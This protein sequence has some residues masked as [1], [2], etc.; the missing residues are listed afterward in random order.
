MILFEKVDES[1]QNLSL[2]EFCV[3]LLTE[4]PTIIFNMNE[5]EKSMV[6]TF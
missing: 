3:H 6:G 2:I 4:L 1:M 5:R